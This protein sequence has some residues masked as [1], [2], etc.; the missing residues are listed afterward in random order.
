MDHP[1]SVDLAVFCV[2]SNND[3][4][5]QIMLF[6]RLKKNETKLTKGFDRSETEKEVGSECGR[7]LGGSERGGGFDEE[8]ELLRP[9]GG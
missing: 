9:G 7:G 3:K 5:S 2:R 4:C 6:S 1:M 8:E